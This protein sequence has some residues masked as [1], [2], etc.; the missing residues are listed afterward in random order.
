M[1]SVQVGLMFVYLFCLFVFGD[2]IFCLCHF[3]CI[4]ATVVVLISC[5][6]YLY[7]VVMVWA[8]L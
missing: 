3:G 2:F 8:I 6:D 4:T 5:I 7:A 1:S